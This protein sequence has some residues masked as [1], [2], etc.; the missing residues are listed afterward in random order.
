[1]YS[2]I[3]TAAGATKLAAGLVNLTDFAIGD[4]GGTAY[5]PTG[6]E[7]ALVNERQRVAIS[8]KIITGNVV[9]VDGTTPPTLN[10]LDSLHVYSDG[11]NWL[12]D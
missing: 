7:V 4:A 8:G 5:V 10:A 6:A 1:M 12:I 2:V 9:T 3:V 11:A